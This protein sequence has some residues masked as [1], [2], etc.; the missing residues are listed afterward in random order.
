MFAGQIPTR[1]KIELI[2]IDEPAFSGTS[3]EGEPTIL[4]QPEV[5]CLCGSDLPYFVEEQPSYPLPVGLSLHEMVGTVLKTSGNRFRVGQKVLAV[6]VGQVGFF[7]RYE[8]AESRAIPLDSRQPFEVSVLAQPLGTAIFA[9]RKLPSLLDQDVV[10]LGQGP[11][12]QIFNACAKLMGARQVIG[13]DRVASRLERS[14][15]MGATTVI[16]SSQDDPIAAVNRLTHDRGADIVVEAVGHANI[17]LNLC[18][19]LCRSFGRILSFGVPPRFEE[20]SIRWWDLFFKNITVHTSVNPDFRRDFP[21]AMQ[22]VGEGR[23]DLSPLITHRL[24]V[25]SIQE[26]YEIFRDKRDGAL[27]VIVDFPAS[28]S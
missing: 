7:E 21:L 18:I 26:A 6:P 9:L 17:A 3:E 25:E 19:D 28:R 16:D 27:K 10:V 12:G 22:W 14:G 20:V 23:I 13:I 4:F 2:D 1:E 11:M 24:P 5:T 8:V 15:P